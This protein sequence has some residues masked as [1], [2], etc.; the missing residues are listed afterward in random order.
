MSK[1]RAWPCKTEIIIPVLEDRNP[2]YHYTDGKIEV[3]CS[4]PANANSDIR[5]FEVQG[6]ERRQGNDSGFI[7]IDGSVFK[8]SEREDV[9]GQVWESF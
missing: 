2:N 4:H 8:G 7:L 3:H 6:C 9:R 1:I 5:W